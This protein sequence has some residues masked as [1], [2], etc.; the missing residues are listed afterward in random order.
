MNF[1]LHPDGTFAVDCRDTAFAPSTRDAWALASYGSF[2]NDHMCCRPQT[3]TQLKCRGA[4]ERASGKIPR[5]DTQ[6]L[7]SYRSISCNECH[8][9]WLKIRTTPTNSIYALGVSE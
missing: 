4:L 6:K 9:T 7:H 1:I 5:S 2:R 3:G 8:T